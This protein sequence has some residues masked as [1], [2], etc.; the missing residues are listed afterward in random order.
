MTILASIN[1][2]TITTEDFVKTLKLKG[3]F[4]ELF[5]VFIQNKLTVHSAGKLGIS[6]KIEEI[7]KHADNFRRNHGLCRAKDTQEYFT[8]LGVTLDDF[9]N[10]IKETIY[11]EMLINKISNDEAIQEYFSLNS[12]DF[13]CV[14]ISHIVLDSED[15]A[16]EILAN[17]GEDPE[18]FS[19]MAREYSSDVNTKDHDGLI[20]KIFRGALPAEM[21]AKVFNASPGDILGPFSLD[22]GNFEIF[23]V[24]AKYPAQLDESTTM[25]IRQLIFQKW[26]AAQTG[27]LKFELV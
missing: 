5:D 19:E 22:E 3:E 6:I 24:K 10:F 11:R 23:M 18:S 25:K 1:D 8:S 17:L 21:D 27:E 16:K 4:D 15:E 7:Q 9:E 2:T 14:E 13:D 12:P 26:L 20:G